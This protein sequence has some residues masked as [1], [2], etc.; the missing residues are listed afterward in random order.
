MASYHS[1]TH[2]SGIVL[3]IFP[4]FAY[5]AD[6]E[7]NFKNNQIIF[8]LINRQQQQLILAVDAYP[9]D[10]G[11]DIGRQAI[12]IDEQDSGIATGIVI[13]LLGSQ[14]D[15][16]QQH[17]DGSHLFENTLQAQQREWQE[18]MVESRWL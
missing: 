10:D 13:Q 16:L 2:G 6:G 14:F 8:S 18:A 1:A 11:F 12:I 9:H 15:G 7:L 17:I 5:D 4:A 3:P